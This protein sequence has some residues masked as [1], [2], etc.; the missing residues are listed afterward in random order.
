MN[1]HVSQTWKKF[2]SF[3]RLQTGDSGIEF[4]SG[5]GINAI[6]ISLE[7][8][9]MTG[10]DISPT[11]VRK[12]VELAKARSSSTRFLVGDMFAPALQGNSFDFA[13]NIWTLHAVGEQDLRDKHLS[14]CYRILRPGGYMFLHNES[15]EV[16]VLCP[17]EEIVIQEIEGWNILECT[18]KF[19]LPD[20]SK[21]EVSFPGHMPPGLSGRRSLREHQAELERAG[22]TVLE[23][24]EDTIRPNPSVPGNRVMIAFAQKKEHPV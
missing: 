20:G 23:C 17:D 4:G 12:A 13:L 24:W 7:G 10:L 8:Y 21:V 2:R 15:S 5:T 3:A 22:F 18:N 14:E 16:D 11:A 9:R 6:T 1:P 19:D